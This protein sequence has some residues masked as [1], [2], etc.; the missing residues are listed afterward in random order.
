MKGVVDELLALV[1]GLTKSEDGLDNSA[2]GH[3][4]TGKSSGKWSMTDHLFHDIID[5][6][7]QKQKNVM[8][9]KIKVKKIIA[10]DDG[11]YDK[12]GF[13]EFNS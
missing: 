9:D 10:G 1:C 11:D 3:H 2:K 4:K 6:K 5:K 7:A 8:S 13:K 12:E